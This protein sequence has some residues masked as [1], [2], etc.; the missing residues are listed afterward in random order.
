MVLIILGGVV[1]LAVLGA[2][3]GLALSRRGAEPKGDPP[4][5]PP[6]GP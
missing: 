5:V 1:V 6:A 2:V 4:D 3:A